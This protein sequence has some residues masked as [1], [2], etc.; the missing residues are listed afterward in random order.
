MRVL[1]TVS[2]C[3]PFAKSGGL[4]DVTGSLPNALKE[5]GLD[6]RVVMPLYKVINEKYDAILNFIGHISIN[7]GWRKQYCGVYTTQLNGIVYYFIDNKYYFDREG[8]YGHFDDGERFAYFST[9]CIE[10]IRLIDYK[11]DII[12][13]HDWHT[14]MIPFLLKYKYRHDDLFKEI[15]SVFTIHNLQ[16]QG[17][18][19]KECLNDFFELGE[20]YFNSH[21]L[22]FNGCISYMK[23]GIVSADQITT[24]SPTYR[25]EIQYEFFGENLDGL[26][27]DKSYKLSGILNGIDTKMYNPSEDKLIKYNYDISTIEKKV[28]NKKDLQQEL[29]LPINS[30]IPVIA[31][32]TRLTG[33]KGIELVQHILHEVL[34]EDVQFILLGSGDSEY[35]SYFRYME[36][37]FKNK[38]RSYIGFNEELA[39]KIYAGSDIFVM[40]SL[41]EPCGLAQMIS[42]R[43][44]T[45][46]IVR[47]TG[48]LNDS[49][50]SY[51]E[52]TDEGNGFTFHNYNAHELLFTIKRAFRYYYEKDVW[53]R[54]MSNAMESDFSWYC[55]AK[56]YKGLYEQVRTLV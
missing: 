38:V 8:F 18:F 32:V 6:V 36:M 27:R 54:I 12:H 50:S 56:K 35:E 2:E 48:G 39:H 28:L 4:A 29:G 40:P 49:V 5:N 47:E 10:F 16:Y 37:N 42:L 46:P 34:Q 11:P 15:R 41:F 1:F 24:V 17:V 21:L 53:R 9:A 25:N 45:I 3:V 7:V 13:C 44:G 43:Y 19:N 31:M 30:H 22:E 23:A 52:L 55:S 33:Q 20:E 14:G 26:L 51:N